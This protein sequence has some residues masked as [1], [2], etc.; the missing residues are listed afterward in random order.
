MGMQYGLMVMMK[1]IKL[2]ENENEE[3]NDKETEII[4]QSITLFGI[5][6]INRIYP[7]D[8]FINDKVNNK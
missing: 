3:E 4:D 5:T 1:I 7:M 2:E 8:I 6:Y